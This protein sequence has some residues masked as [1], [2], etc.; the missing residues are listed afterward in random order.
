MP[1]GRAFFPGLTNYIKTVTMPMIHGIA[2]GVGSITAVPFAG[3][4]NTVGDLVLT[5]DSTTIRFRDCS[6]VN[7]SLKGGANS[8]RMWSLSVL[9][10]RWKWKFGEVSGRYNSLRPDNDL[11]ERTEKTPRELATLLL[12]AMGEENYDIS[13][14]PDTARP[15]V[16]WY[17]ANPALELQNLCDSL[18]C[19]VIL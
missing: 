8:P 19:R 12:D 10:R 1:T 17:F 18:G 6:I 5:Y 4:A 9:D 16:N 2:P 14:L 7:P 3:F 11:D 13:A 15:H